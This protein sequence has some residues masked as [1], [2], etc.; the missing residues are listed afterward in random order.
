[1]AIDIDSTIVGRWRIVRQRR[2][3]RIQWRLLR[4]W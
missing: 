1:L 3:G 4:Y 2:L